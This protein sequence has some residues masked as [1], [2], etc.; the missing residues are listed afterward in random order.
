M[1][2]VFHREVDLYRRRQVNWHEN[3]EI[4]YC[5]EGSGSV[6]C[7][8]RVHTMCAGDIIAINSD[9]IH[10]VL[11]SEH[12][13]YHCLIIDRGFCESNGIPVTTL[14]FQE[15]IEDAQLGAA[16]L[17][18][19]AAYDA[20]SREHAVYSAAQIRA[21]VIELLC[22]LCKSYIQPRKDLSRSAGTEAVKS[23]LLYIKQNYTRQ[24]TLEEI[25]GHAGIS[26]CYLS[27][28]FKKHTGKTVFEMILLIRC[29]EA[30]RLLQGALRFR[31]RHLPAALRAF[32]ISVRPLKRSAA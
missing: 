2:F 4:L 7:N 3:L 27:R 1:P 30:T 24:M 16:F 8:E 13:V 29:K 17:D 20:Q 31:R 12:V 25:A 23:T 28:E 14:W 21:K 19:C 15:K 26:Q 6:K 9:V 32:P 11:D 5:V 18:V 22:L 10:Q